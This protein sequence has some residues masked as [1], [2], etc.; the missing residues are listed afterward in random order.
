MP[1]SSGWPGI[2]EEAGQGNAA[3]IQSSTKLPLT[4]MPLPAPPAKLYTLAMQEIP[5]STG[6]RLGRKKP[7]LREILECPQSH[8]Q[9]VV[10]PHMRN[11]L[12]TSAGHT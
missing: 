10:R 1:H 11:P 5:S 8:Q 6:S 12:P 7:K 3:G 4:H 9:Q 2:S